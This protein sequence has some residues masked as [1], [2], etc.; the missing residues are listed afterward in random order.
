MKTLYGFNSELF[1]LYWNRGI[2]IY[3]STHPAFVE[4]CYINKEFD[5]DLTQRYRKKYLY[6]QGEFVSKGNCTCSGLD[7]NSSA[8]PCVCVAQDKEYQLSF[9]AIENEDKVVNLPIQCSKEITDIAHNIA[10]WLYFIV[11]IL[12]IGITLVLVFSPLNERIKLKHVEIKD[13]KTKNPEQSVYYAKAQTTENNV[14][15]EEVNTEQ[16]T[17]HFSFCTV[18]GDNFKLLHP[19]CSL[20]KLSFTQ[21][22]LYL[23]LI[24]V[25]NILSI[26]GRNALYFSEDMIEK[27]IYAE[28]RNTFVYPSKKSVEQS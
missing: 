25:F 23:L 19:L 5:Y 6:Q 10:F 2:N 27:R 11:L 4:K 14:R 7:G 24:L 15:I 1:T 28:D 12:T 3:N 9:K 20:C 18:Y 22:V 21:P 8:L 17:I 26:F 13:T 16:I